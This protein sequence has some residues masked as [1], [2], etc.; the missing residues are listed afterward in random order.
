MSVISIR[1]VPVFSTVKM[2]F[3]G[4]G[5][6]LISSAF[7]SETVVISVT[8]I[9]ALKAYDSAQLNPETIAKNPVLFTDTSYNLI[10][11]AAIVEELVTSITAYE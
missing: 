4:F 2:S 1:Y 3:T 8:F 6:I 9:P 7:C 5:K 10:G 11:V